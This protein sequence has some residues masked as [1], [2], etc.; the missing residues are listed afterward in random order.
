MVYC[1][2]TTLT[3]ISRAYTREIFT[4]RLINANLSKAWQLMV[5]QQEGKKGVRREIWVFYVCLST[6]NRISLGKQKA[7][8]NTIFVW[9]PTVGVRKELNALY[10]Y[11]Q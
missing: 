7:E 1:G 11:C 10:R 8:V 3:L 6:S 2:I 5:L 9:H 4:A